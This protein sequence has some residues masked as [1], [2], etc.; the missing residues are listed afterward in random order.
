MRSLTQGQ[1]RIEVPGKTVGALI[2][3]L[4]ELYPGIRARLCAGD[5]LSP[6]LAVYIDN[7][8]SSR[9]LAARVGA[10]GEIHFLPAVSG[11]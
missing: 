10:D 5:E 1:D 11:G 7:Q 8:L 9:G 4:D 3:S 6:E 2:D